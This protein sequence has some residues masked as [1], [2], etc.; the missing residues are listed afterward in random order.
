MTN[1]KEESSSRCFGGYQKT[2]SHERFAN[3]YWSQHRFWRLSHFTHS[4]LEASAILWSF[5]CSSE[6]KCKMTFS[7]YIPENAEKGKCPVLYWLSGLTCTEQ[8]FIIKSGFQRIA[9]EFGFVV[10]G[11]D[12]S[13][14]K[15]PYQVSYYRPRSRFNCTA[16]NHG[17]FVVCPNR[18]LQC[19]RRKRV[20]GLRR[21]RRLLLGRN[22]AQMGSELAH[23]QLRDSRVASFG[24]RQLPSRRRSCLCERPLDGR[25]R[26]AYFCAQK[27]EP[28]S[29][30]FCVRSHLE[31]VHRNLGH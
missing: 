30:C 27:S 28:V 8:N 15:Q 19:G 29:E 25:P 21:W 11:P 26:S 5:V 24:E 4:Y 1:L 13:P 10:I 16:L 6:T 17:Y 3:F 12:T 20:V 31:S 22:C 2:F 18:W 14:R 23:G 7:A 9:N